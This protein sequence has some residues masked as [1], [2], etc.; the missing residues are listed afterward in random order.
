MTLAP[1]LWPTPIQNF[2]SK[3]SVSKTDT[4]CLLPTICMTCSTKPNDRELSYI[5]Y[6]TDTLL[7]TLIRV[8]LGLKN[9]EAA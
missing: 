6:Q 2:N 8:D 1:D 5:G 4:K 3:Q 9:G 7:F